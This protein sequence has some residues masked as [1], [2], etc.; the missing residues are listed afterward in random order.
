VVRKARL[1]GVELIFV[2]G[3]TTATAQPLDIS[4]MGPFAKQ[5]QI[6]W[7]QRRRGEIDS[8]DNVRSAILAAL[9]AWE[10]VSTKSCQE[11]WKVIEGERKHVL[12][13]P[14]DE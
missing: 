7:L 2:P 14:I 13:I 11:G 6:Q 10:K 3:G 9:E 1:M 12:P 8:V 4:V 5:R